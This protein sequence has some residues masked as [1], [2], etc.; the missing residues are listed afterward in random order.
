MND[1]FS[2]LTKGATFS[3]KQNAEQMHMFAKGGT[4]QK[5]PVLN[6]FCR[7]GGRGK[8]TNSSNHHSSDSEENQAASDEHESS[9]DS[10]CS[11]D[12]ASDSDSDSER[13][14]R[15]KA[16][17]ER[18]IAGRSKRVR[19]QSAK[20]EINAFRN[21][22]QIKVKGN[23]VPPPLATFDEF[24]LHSSGKKEILA[25]VEEGE[26]KEPTAVQM[27]AIPALLEG[28]D[29]LAAAPT[30]SGKTA[31]FLLPLISRLLALSMAAR[32]NATGDSEKRVDTSNGSSSSGG[33]SNSNNSSSSSSSSSSKTGGIRA[34]VLA[35]TR[36]LAEQIH[37][38]AERLYSGRKFKAILLTAALVATAERHKGS[39]SGPL[40]SG[41]LLISTPL[42]LLAA[43]RSGIVDLSGVRLV[44]LDEADKLFEIEGR[45][46]QR[47]DKDKHKGTRKEGGLGPGDTVSLSAG[48][49][50]TDRENG[51]NP[52]AYEESGSEGE[53]D[54]TK[55]EVDEEGGGVSDES[56]DPE[57]LA[58]QCLGN[59][60]LRQIDEIFAGCPTA[61]GVCQKALFS[62][63][64]G[65]LV[66][67]LASSFLVDPVHIT[68]GRPN[69]GNAAIE[70][71]LVFTGNEQ[72]VPRL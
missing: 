44:V 5:K 19:A 55:E 71:K 35:P 68:I 56:P 28:R 12:D 6:L 57:A 4:H 15:R 21:R 20:D 24:P 66:L 34:L 49:S 18:K 25:A 39:S 61:P 14:Q 63:T 32:A 7:A 11:S 37:R 10:E 26:W 48:K 62:A 51:R 2:Q 67:E 46:A 53:S 45:R 22:L 29:V 33:N 64:L 27:Q 50:L 13:V 58:E 23:N 31:A 69:T 8:E 65:P 17:K 38:E 40:S 59:S 36:E 47:K 3:K 60:F 9:S 54:D 1:I 16:K 72:G 30:G 41:D 70:Q 52:A 42:R 43:V